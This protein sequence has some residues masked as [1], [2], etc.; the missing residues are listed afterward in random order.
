MVR[1]LFLVPTSARAARCL[2][3]ASAAPAATSLA[4]TSLI[5][6]VCARRRLL[7]RGGLFMGHPVLHLCPGILF[8]TVMM[9][10]HMQLPSFADRIE[11]AVAATLKVWFGCASCRC[12]FVDECDAAPPGC[13]HTYKG[14]GWFMLHQQVRRRRCCKAVIGSHIFPLRWYR[15]GKKNEK[16]QTTTGH[17]ISKVEVLPHKLALLCAQTGVC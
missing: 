1:V 7:L 9:L 2:S 13:I 4:R 10:R 3:R 11:G 17:R 5:L 8:S 12:G 6:L 16:N 14:F 15:K